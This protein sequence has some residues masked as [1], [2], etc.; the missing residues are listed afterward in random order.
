MKKLLTPLAALFFTISTIAG[1][2]PR[3]AFGQFGIQYS[4]AL[5]GYMSYVGQTVEYLPAMKDGYPWLEDT[6]NFEHKGG[7][8]NKKYIITI[9][10]GFDSR[11]YFHLSPIDE[12]KKCKLVFDNQIVGDRFFTMVPPYCIPLLLSD[13][14]ESYRASKLWTVIPEGNEDCAHL[15]IEDV[16]WGNL[17]EGYDHQYPSLLYKLKKSYNGSEVICSEEDFPMYQRLGEVVGRV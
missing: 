16:F 13:V 8:F 2:H 3:A 14:F 15:T 9:V 7:Y 11:V 12:G 4:Q 17:K 1:P 5:S 6:F 10:S